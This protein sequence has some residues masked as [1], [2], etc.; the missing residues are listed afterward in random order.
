MLVAAEHPE[1]VT[2]LVLVAP[3]TPETPIAGPSAPCGRRSSG[4]LALALAIGRSWRSASASAL[5]GRRRA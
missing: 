1:R 4:E 2:A 3:A 5:R